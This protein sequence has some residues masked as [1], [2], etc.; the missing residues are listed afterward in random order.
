MDAS[1]D[2]H[3]HLGSMCSYSPA[4]KCS[5]ALTRLAKLVLPF[6]GCLKEPANPE[7]PLTRSLG[8]PVVPHPPSLPLHHDQHEIYGLA[9]LPSLLLPRW[10]HALP[11]LASPNISSQLPAETGKGE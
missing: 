7:Q 2:S 10:Q 9:A 3:V 6:K 5:P 1:L 8:P 4:S 11:F